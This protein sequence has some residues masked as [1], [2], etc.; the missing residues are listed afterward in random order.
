MSEG[1]I[2]EWNCIREVLGLKFGSGSRFSECAFSWVS[3]SHQENSEIEPWFC[4][5]RLLP[6]PFQYVIHLSSYNPS[7]CSLATESV[8]KY[9]RFSTKAVQSDT[10]FKSKNF[11]SLILRLT[12]RQIVQSIFTALWNNLEVLGLHSGECSNVSQDATWTGITV[13]KIV[14]NLWIVTIVRVLWSC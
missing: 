1:N 13:K 14:T 4:H 7:H 11:Q 10:S 8:V 9:L 2:A 3:Q 12:L 6:N 5:D